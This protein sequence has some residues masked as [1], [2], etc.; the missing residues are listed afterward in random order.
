MSRGGPWLARSGLPRRAAKHGDTDGWGPVG[1]SAG[2]KRA[3]WGMDDQKSGR[4]LRPP[5]HDL[6]YFC[7]RVI[8]KID[9]VD[10]FHRLA[11]LLIEG[12]LGCRYAAQRLA[13]VVRFQQ[14]DCDCPVRRFLVPHRVASDPVRPIPTVVASLASPL[15]NP[16]NI[17]RSASCFPGMMGRTNATE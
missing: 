10:L 1:R 11:E 2:A 14:D 15:L 13:D 3:L 6:G 16:S 5:V 17:S 9:A 8:R 7:R 12:L 4:L